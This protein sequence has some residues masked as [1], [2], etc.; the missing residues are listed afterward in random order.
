MTAVIIAGGGPPV[1][2]AGVRA[3]ESSGFIS[4]L[5]LSWLTER[6]SVRKGHFRCDK[7][8]QAV[9]PKRASLPGPVCSA[10]PTGSISP[11]QTARVSASVCDTLVFTGDVSKLTGNAVGVDNTG[12]HTTETAQL[13]FRPAGQL[14][15][16]ILD[17]ET[18]GQ[19][20]A[21]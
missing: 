5:L 20:Q 12:G 18:G 11:I 6:L 10:L 21:S 4:F 9:R 15:L 8:R 13:Q 17:P 14:Q 1:H 3:A 7:T 16:A 19:T 2:P